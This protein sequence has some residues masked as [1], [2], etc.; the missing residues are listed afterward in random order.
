MNVKCKKPKQKTDNH[1][2]TKVKLI[3][4]NRYILPFTAHRSLFTSYGID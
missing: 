4:I 3:Y 1:E 2:N